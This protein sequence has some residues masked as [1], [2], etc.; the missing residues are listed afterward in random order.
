MNLTYLNYN[1]QKYGCDFIWIYEILINKHS[2]IDFVWLVLYDSVEQVLQ[3][4]DIKVKGLI[5]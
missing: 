2:E 3:W 1:L 5:V 4:G